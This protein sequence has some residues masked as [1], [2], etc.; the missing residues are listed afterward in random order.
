MALRFILLKCSRKV[1]FGLFVKCAGLPTD[2]RIGQTEN[3]LIGQSE[4]KWVISTP[5]S[6][7]HSF[8]LPRCIILKI[9]H[10]P[11]SHASSKF[12]AYNRH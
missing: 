11:S 4:R 9:S 7:M 10:R 2:T 6:K 5:I 3:L 12:Q 8:Q 1:I